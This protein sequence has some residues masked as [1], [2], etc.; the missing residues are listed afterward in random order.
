MIKTRYVHLPT[1]RNRIVILEYESR[2][3]I[4]KRH[5]KPVIVTN[6]QL[7]SMGFGC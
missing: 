4:Q 5:L 7:I 2:L 1:N 3:V 6:K